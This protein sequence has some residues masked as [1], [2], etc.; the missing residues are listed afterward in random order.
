[1]SRDFDF[2]FLVSAFE[3]TEPLTELVN[4]ITN[5]LAVLEVSIIVHYL[6]YYAY[7]GMHYRC[8]EIWLLLL[9]KYCR[10][11]DLETQLPYLDPLVFKYNGARLNMRLQQSC[12]HF[13]GQIDRWLQHRGNI[14]DARSNQL[15]R[16]QVQDDWAFIFVYDPAQLNI[17]PSRQDSFKWIAQLMCYEDPD[18]MLHLFPVEGQL[19]PGSIRRWKRSIVQ[20][21]V[22]PNG[23]L[24]LGDERQLQLAIDSFQWPSNDIMAYRE[25]QVRAGEAIE[26]NTTGLPSW[27]YQP[28][29]LAT[30]NDK[31]QRRLLSLAPK[32]AT[33]DISAYVKQVERATADSFRSDEA[34]VLGTG[35]KARE[36]RPK[37]FVANLNDSRRDSLLHRWNEMVTDGF[38]TS[39]PDRP[40][41][42]TPDKDQEA[43]AFNAKVHSLKRS[44]LN[45]RR[46]ERVT[47]ILEKVI[48][49][50]STYAA[51]SRTNFNKVAS[52]RQVTDA[53]KCPQVIE[54]ERTNFTTTLMILEPVINPK[55]EIPCMVVGKR[56]VNVETLAKS[57][58]KSHQ[59]DIL[60][61]FRNE[62]DKD[63]I[64]KAFS[65]GD[66]IRKPLKNPWEYCSDGGGLVGRTTAA[67]LAR[68]ALRRPDS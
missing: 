26:D 33:N 1:M 56:K 62:T 10:I 18:V 35:L 25:K 15:Q 16:D 3:V 7:R 23:D 13:Q 63:E 29:G 48:D 32:P 54:D 60:E 24:D 9:V 47:L 65:R 22:L 52:E 6:R 38:E 11:T 34:A 19:P 5:P 59:L 66:E 51:V 50:N 64:R 20:D 28:D 40:L 39:T 53:K 67:L 45:K 44:R 4:D 8:L 14:D 37:F 46:I 43:F 12:A 21:L 31:E 27:Q 55:R 68:A 49:G 58:D 42:I 17:L 36:I 61:L 41:N 57:L 2:D 30:L